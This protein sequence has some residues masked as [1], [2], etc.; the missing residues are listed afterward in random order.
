ME[1]I[2]MWNGEEIDSADTKKEAKY[3]IQE[4]AMAFNSSVGNFTIVEK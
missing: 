1:Y 2:I 4:Y 3:L